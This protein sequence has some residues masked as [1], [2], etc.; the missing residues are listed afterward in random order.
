[1][2]NP[3]AGTHKQ[4][5]GPKQASHIPQHTVVSHNWCTWQTKRTNEGAVVNQAVSCTSSFCPSSPLHPI[6]L[7]A[8]AHRGSRHDDPL[9][10]KRNDGSIAFFSLS[11]LEP[12]RYAWTD[13]AYR[14]RQS[15]AAALAASREH[16]CRRRQGSRSVRAHG[17]LLPCLFLSF[18]A[19]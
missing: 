17:C 15:A 5:P 12:L 13:I 11:C 7:R 4:G 14:P 8:P 9:A 10:R 19:V 1:M 16:H 2:I 18:R 6:P 3:P